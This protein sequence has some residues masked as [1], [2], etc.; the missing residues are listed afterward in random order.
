M[1]ATELKTNEIWIE[2]GT[3]FYPIFYYIKLPR[4]N[5]NFN[6]IFVRLIL[7]LPQN[8]ARTAPIQIE[9]PHSSRGIQ[10]N[11]FKMIAASK[12]PNIIPKVF[13]VNY[14]INLNRN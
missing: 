9:L 8:F 14:I 10:T 13:H 4:R 1:N 2:F 12:F 5:C 3:V 11:S 7:S 6:Q